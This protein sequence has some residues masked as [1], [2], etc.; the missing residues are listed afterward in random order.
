[1]RSNKTFSVGKALFRANCF[2]QNSRPEQV[3]ERIGTFGLMES[4]LHAT[5][6]YRGFGYLNMVAKANGE[7]Y[8]I[9]DESR[10]C[11]IIHPNLM[12]DYKAAEKHY[13]EVFG[14]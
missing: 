13:Q 6:N 7:G 8:D 2:L 4:I 14:A 1:M 9:P 3:G 5:G 10:T 11:F 12:A